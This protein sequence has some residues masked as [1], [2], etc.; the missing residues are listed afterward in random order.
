MTKRMMNP[1]TNSIGVRS[2]GL[3]AHMV[4]SQAK[5]WTPD[6][7]TMRKL[8]SEM[9]PRPI[10]GSPVANMWWTHTPKPSRAIAISARTMYV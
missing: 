10:V 8:V 3:P 4:A 9:N 2:T 5:I 6:G 1:S 7:M